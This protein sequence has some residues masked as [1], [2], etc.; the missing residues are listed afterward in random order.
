MPVA[1]GY[2]R[3]MSDIE[4]TIHTLRLVTGSRRSTASCVT[5]RKTDKNRKAMA[6]RL[7]AVAYWK[8]VLHAAKYPHAQV[9]GVLIG[10]F[11]SGSDGAAAAGSSSAGGGAALVV[12]DAAPLVHGAFVL[13]PPLEIA[14]SQVRDCISQYFLAADGSLLLFYRERRSRRRAKQ[15][16]HDVAAVET[17][18]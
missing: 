4:P 3:D 8:M 5:R 11:R 17:R 10:A 9:A 6:V 14:L 16:V 18:E 12:S 7:Q 13:A 15:S 2:T 1:L